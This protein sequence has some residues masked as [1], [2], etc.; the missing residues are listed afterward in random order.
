MKV[1]IIAVGTEL[2][3]GQTVN[4]NAVYLSRELN[5]MGFDVMYHHTV[6]DNPA[7]LVEMLDVAY[8]DCDMV[9]TTG[10]LGPTQDDLTK[11]ILNDYFG[12]ELVLHEPSMES[13]KERFE[14]LGR[15]MTD[16]NIK[17][18]YMPSRSHVFRN[19]QGTA[20][21]CALEKDGKYAI[22]L[23]GPPREM[24]AMFESYVR[25][26]LDGKTD[27]S[28][29]YR[30]I[31]TFGIGESD[32]ET[33]LMDIIDGQTDPT[34]ATYAKEGECYLRIASK[35]ADAAEAESA[36]EGM[37]ADVKERIGEFIYDC[38]NRDLWDVV[39]EKLMERNITISS[40]ESCTGGMFAEKLTSVPGISAVFG[41]SFVTYSNEAKEEI[42][43][44]KKETLEQ[45]GAVSEETAMEMAKGLR[46]VS[47]SRI[48][49]SVT[50]VA[51]PDG[52]TPEK[53]VGLVYIGAVCDDKE[54]CRKVQMRNISR[55]WNRNFS[56]LHMFDVVNRLIDGIKD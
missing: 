49:V 3:F 37:L 23:P 32:L 50:G 25:P 2:L 26:Y 44:V 6:G 41:R 7:R 12:D 5:L 42:L 39:G 46:K 47:G 8:K 53:P 15:K 31:R 30:L 29:C 48:C 54:V 38:D 55:Q 21:G 9:I 43:G 10:G 40:A 17:Q 1:A 45:H 11:E 20:P 24:T 14:K 35:R 27:G 16:N 36:V 19:D 22:C 13:M 4:T 34:L 51:G 28:M 52:G 33:R 18:A 56:M